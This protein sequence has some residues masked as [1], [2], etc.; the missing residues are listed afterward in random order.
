VTRLQMTPFGTQTN[1]MVYQPGGFKF[2]DYVKLGLPLTLLTG[3][4]TAVLCE[5]LIDA[6]MPS[7][8]TTVSTV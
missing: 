8:N 5:K 1:L 3:V 6:P 7:P 4:S 2:A